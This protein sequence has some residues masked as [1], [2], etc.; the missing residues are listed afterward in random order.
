VKIG[1]GQGKQKENG[2][3]GEGRSHGTRTWQMNFLGEDQSRADEA[4]S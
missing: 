3:G 1:A 4:G 2:V